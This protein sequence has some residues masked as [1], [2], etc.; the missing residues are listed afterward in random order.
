[1]HKVVQKGRAAPFSIVGVSVKERWG[2]QYWGFNINFSFV[3][4]IQ[5]LAFI[6]I[7]L[8]CIALILGAGWVQEWDGLEEPW[9]I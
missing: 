3:C 4:T 2:L 1:M 7:C 5:F 9:N 6:G 8:F